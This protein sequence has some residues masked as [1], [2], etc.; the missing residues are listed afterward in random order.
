MRI[1][2]MPLRMGAGEIAGEMADFDERQG[3]RCTSCSE[4]AYSGTMTGRARHKLAVLEH[5]QGGSA[6]D[7]G[8]PSWRAARSTRP[9]STKNSLR[10]L[11]VAAGV[12]V[13]TRGTSS[14]CVLVPRSIT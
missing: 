7:Y 6:D 1:L 12:S 3:S 9:R 8:A 2:A 14:A 13:A 11:R 10:W 5:H 4:G